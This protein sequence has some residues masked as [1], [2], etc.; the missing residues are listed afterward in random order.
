MSNSPERDLS[1]PL[2]VGAP[3]L[4]R[5]GDRLPDVVATVV[6][7]AGIAQEVDRADHEVEVPGLEQ[8]RQLVLGAAHVVGLDAELERGRADESQ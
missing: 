6:Y 1:D 3:E 5:V 2:E 4:V 7:G 8:A